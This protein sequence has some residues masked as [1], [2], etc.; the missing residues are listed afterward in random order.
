VNQTATLIAQ[1]ARGRALLFGLPV[2]ESINLGLAQSSENLSILQSELLRRPATER[3]TGFGP[4]Q[5]LLDDPTVEEIWINRPDEIWFAT[6]Q[7]NQRQAVEFSA[8]QIETVVE[9]LLRSTGRRIDRTSPFV[10]AGL[11]DGSRLHV[12]IPSVTRSNWCVNIRKFRQDASSLSWLQSVGMISGEQ[13]RQLDDA[14]RSGRSILVSGATQAGKTTVLTALLNAVSVG[15]RIVT[16]EDTFEINCN[17]KDLVAMQTREAT[18]DGAAEVDMRRLVRESLRMRPSRIAVGE[19]RG[20]EA[21]DLLLALNSG[22]PGFCTIHANSAVEALEKLSSLP[23]LASANLSADFASRMVK[24]AVGLV[25]HCE[26]ENNGKRRV[27]QILEL[28]DAI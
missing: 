22:I 12:V 17:A 7:G 4:L 25:V 8:E 13:A 18:P 6:A 10:D 21:L 19:V 24:T 26:R 27:T 3:L 20:A 2:D 9:R 15:E 1:Q 23:M 14:V 11:S 16:I 5:T 28:K